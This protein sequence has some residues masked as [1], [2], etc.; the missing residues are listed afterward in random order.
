MKKRTIIIIALIL[1]FLVA[2]VFV[3][4]RFKGTNYRVLVNK[5]HPITEGFL[6]NVKLVDVTTYDGS[7]AQV[8]EKTYQAF[9]KLQKAL[10]AK[11]IEIEVDSGYRSMEYQ[12]WI[13]DEFTELYGE[14][15]ARKT[16]A[17]PGT[18]EHHTG[19][20]ID[21]VPR[22]NGVWVEEN[23]DMIKEEA[24]FKIVHETLSEYGFILRYPKGKEAITGYDYEPWHFRYVG[25]NIAKE[26]Y[27]KGITF[28]EYLGK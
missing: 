10:L 3:A 2:A 9:L 7:T 27:E 23:E 26:I 13:M 4:S 24:L 22:V 16:V 19:M 18:S 21:I 14:E 6:K 17:V 11:G 25:K 28:E 20:A 1:V 15:Y 8:E 12:Q 5:Q